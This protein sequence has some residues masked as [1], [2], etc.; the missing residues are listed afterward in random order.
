MD[1]SA[2]G[3]SLL[4]LHT[5]NPVGVTRHS[6]MA[7]VLTSKDVGRGEG[8]FQEGR[9]HFFDVLLTSNVLCMN[10]YES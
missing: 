8:V 2:A 5:T 3:I 6:S 4:P 10:V 7:G 9:V 1:L